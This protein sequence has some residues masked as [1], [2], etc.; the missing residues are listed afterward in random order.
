MNPTMSA[1]QIMREQRRVN[2]ST[3]Q[4]TTVSV[5]TGVTQFHFEG[6]DWIYAVQKIKDFSSDPLGDWKFTKMAEYY[7]KLGDEMIRYREDVKQ[8]KRDKERAS[9]ISQIRIP[10]SNGGVDKVL[11]TTIHSPE[12]VARKNVTNILKM[13]GK[14]NPTQQEVDIMIQQMRAAGAKI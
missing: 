6:S 14:S 11:S 1:A 4:I 12:E 9:G 13:M 10:G 2:P 7:K 8:A 5:D 3:G